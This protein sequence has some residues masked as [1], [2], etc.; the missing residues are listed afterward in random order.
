MDKKKIGCVIMASGLG[1]RFGSNKLL[2][3]FVGKTLFEH[4]LELTGGNLFAKRVVVTRN[5]AVREICDKQNVEVIFHAYPDRNDT[6][7]LG[8]GQMDEMDACVFCPCDQPLL[9]RASLKKILREY[10]AEPAAE[11]AILRL[12]YEGK[13]GAPVLFG[14]AQFE[15]LKT[16]PPKKGG[17]YLAKKYPE[18]VRL[19]AASNE[20]ELFDVDTQEDLK[21]LLSKKFSHY[22]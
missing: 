11:T 3:E 4:T 8:I 18:I 5:D 1:L 20:W 12:S 13:V 21:L 22:L 15:E 17:A 16:L 14:K 7:R 6:V 9:Q 10:E 2:A 19:V